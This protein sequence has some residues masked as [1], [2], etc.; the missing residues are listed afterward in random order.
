MEVL[1][2]Q[3]NT[4]GEKPTWFQNTVPLIQTNILLVWHS[5]KLRVFNQHQKL[6]KL[7]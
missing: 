7:F 3:Q 5:Q 1:D 2:C 6:Q 4:A